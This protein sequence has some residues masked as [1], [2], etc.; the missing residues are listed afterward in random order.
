MS[1]DSVKPI[2]LKLDF[3][4]YAFFFQNNDLNLFLELYYIDQLLKLWKYP[5]FIVNKNEYVNELSRKCQG[6]W[7]YTKTCDSCHVLRNYSLV[8]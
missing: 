5:D 4:L 6:N 3:V 8:N 2:E 7:H 1:D